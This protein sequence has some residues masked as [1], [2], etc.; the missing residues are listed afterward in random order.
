MTTGSR[1]FNQ[2]VDSSFYSATRMHSADY[3]MARCLSVRLSVCL[4]HAGIVGKRL[5]ISSKIFH[6]RVA[7]SHS[8]FR[9]KRDGNIPTRSPQTRA[10]NA[11]DMKNH[12]F[13]PISRFISQTMQHRAIV[14]MEGE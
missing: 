4:S 9:T 13:Q 11:R 5:Y 1:K 7:P 3:T 14:T 6:H 8:F 2:G 12:D 10:S